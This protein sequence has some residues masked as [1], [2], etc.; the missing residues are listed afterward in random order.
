MILFVL[1]VATNIYLGRMIDRID[2]RG[3]NPDFPLRYEYAGTIIL[4]GLTW[5]HLVEVWK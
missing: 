1:M 5:S 3:F 2:R 4:W